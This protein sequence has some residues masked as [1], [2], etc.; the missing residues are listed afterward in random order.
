MKLRTLFAL[1]V[2]GLV[3]S[4]C[5]IHHGPPVAYGYSYGYV[6]RPYYGYARPHHGHGKHWGHHHGRHHHGGHHGRGHG[7]HGW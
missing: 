3:L 1:A 7:R 6:E 5:H 4:A 2:T